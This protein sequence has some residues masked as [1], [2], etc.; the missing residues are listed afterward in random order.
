[1]RKYW[2]SLE[3]YHDLPGIDHESSDREFKASVFELF[4]DDISKKSSS[5][6]DFL[7]IFGFSV[8]SAAILA[9]CERPV[10]KAIRLKRRATQP[11]GQA[12]I[13]VTRNPEPSE[14][15]DF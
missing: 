15:T 12:Q 10:Q 6:R 1:M 14:S 13:G 7:K 2:K 9:S 11:S 3:E 5:R 8:T 4:E